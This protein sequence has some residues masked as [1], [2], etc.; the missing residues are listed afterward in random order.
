MATQAQKNDISESSSI[1]PYLKDKIISEIE[2]SVMAT[3][4]KSLTGS[5]ATK[6]ELFFKEIF[7][8]SSE[9]QEESIKFYKEAAAHKSSLI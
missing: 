5:F 6:I 2:T 3:L 9:I 7:K 4:K 8:Q 1:A